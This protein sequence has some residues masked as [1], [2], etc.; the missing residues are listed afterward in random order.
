MKVEV[1][2]S[3]NKIYIFCFILLEIFRRWCQGM[4][5]PQVPSTPSLNCRIAN[6]VSTLS[7]Q[8]VFG[9]LLQGKGGPQV[10]TITG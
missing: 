9:A 2:V 6:S 1:Y 8:P 5:R 3:M 7:Q 4:G 10:L